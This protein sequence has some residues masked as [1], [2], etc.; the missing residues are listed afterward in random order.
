MPSLPPSV[1]KVRNGDSM[2]AMTR[3]TIA[4]LSA[5]QVFL[6][7]VAGRLHPAIIAKLSREGLDGSGRFGIGSDAKRAADSVCIPLQKAADNLSAAM[8]LINK[9]AQNFD[10]NVVQPVQKARYERDHQKAGDLNF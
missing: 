1:E 4:A 6:G 9:A 7:N 8:K 10:S 2:N 5:G 3:A